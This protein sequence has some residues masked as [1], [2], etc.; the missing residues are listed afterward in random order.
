M[1]PHGGRGASSIPAAGRVN[2][3]LAAATEQDKD[4]HGFGRDVV[5]LDVT[6][7]NMSPIGEGDTQWLRLRGC[8][9]GNGDYAQVVELVDPQDQTERMDEVLFDAICEALSAVPDGGSGFWVA[10]PGAD[11]WV[12][13]A[14]R[15]G[16]IGAD[17]RAKALVG[18]WQKLGLLIPDADAKDDRKRPVK[19]A[20]KLNQIMAAKYRSQRWGG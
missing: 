3:T 19:T 8:A 15:T 14:F 12:G 5:R 2:E 11:N 18:E 7:A 17:G 13:Q 4:R 10:K 9:V 6:K 1:D 20:T 16:G